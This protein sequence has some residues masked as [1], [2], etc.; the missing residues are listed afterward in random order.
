MKKTIL[1]HFRAK[2]GHFSDYEL[3]EWILFHEIS[4]TIKINIV[5]LVW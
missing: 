2:I 5:R 3:L 4:L 1:E